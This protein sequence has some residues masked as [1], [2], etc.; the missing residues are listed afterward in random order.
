MVGNVG[1]VVA[2]ALTIPVLYAVVT[3]VLDFYIRW[4]LKGR[5]VRGEYRIWVEEEDNPHWEFHAG[6]IEKLV[7]LHGNGGR[8]AHVEQAVRFLKG[9]LYSLGLELTAGA[10]AVDVASLTGGKGAPGYLAWAVLFHSVLLFGAFA[11]LV[12]NQRADP[13][14]VWRMRIT[15]TLA[16]LVGLTAMGTSF[17]ALDAEL[18]SEILNVGDR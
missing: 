16:I 10:I 4:E 5:R 2:F 15:A 18:V 17:L 8:V 3:K 11:L 1:L 6:D 7:A 13:D 9:N 14:E 12:S